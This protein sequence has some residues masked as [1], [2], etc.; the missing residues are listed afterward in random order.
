MQKFENQ[1]VS[2]EQCPL[3]RCPKEWRN[4]HDFTQNVILRDLEFENCEFIGQGLASYGGP[5]NRSTAQNIRLKN[6][7][8]NSFAGIGAIFD[9]IVVDGLRTSRSPAILFGCALRH[10][11]LT[12]K[13][14]RFLFNRNVCHDD[15]K[16]NASFNS[17]NAEFYKNVD[18]A[19]DISSLNPAGLEIRGTIP[20]RLIRRNPE[21][22][23]IM[24]RMVALE[25]GWKNYDPFDV[26]QISVSTFLDSG[27]EDNLFIAPKQSKNFREQIEFFHRL[28]TAGLMT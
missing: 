22:H 2:K 16:R 25:G 23:Y 26:F 9:E 11:V 13:C 3:E 17:A 27:A 10:V 15:Q 6:C 19:L 28:K 1:I 14:G 24:T 4:S 7:V 21:V 8:V 5:I 18:W 20:S 12:G